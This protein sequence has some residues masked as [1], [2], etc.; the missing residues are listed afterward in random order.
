MVFSPFSIHLA[1]AMLSSAATPGSTTQE[2]LLHVLGGLENNKK[3]E[4]SWKYLLD[5]Y[6]VSLQ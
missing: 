5:E 1:L 6:R 2:E 3:L 4:K